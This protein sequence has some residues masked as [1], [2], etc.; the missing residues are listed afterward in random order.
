MWKSVGNA[1]PSDAPPSLEQAKAALVLA[2]FEAATK[3]IESPGESYTSLHG[4]LKTLESNLETEASRSK[5]FPATS[6]GRR[7]ALARWMTD[8]RHPLTAR[9]AVNHIW[10][11][12]FGSAGGGLVP[13]VFDFGRKGTPPTHPELLDWLAVEFMEHGWSMKHLHRLM[14][15]SAAYRMSSSQIENQKSN[16][17]GDSRPER[18]AIFAERGRSICGI[19][20]SASSDWTTRSRHSCNRPG[21][22]GNTRDVEPC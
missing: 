20:K 21:V 14:V 4:A 19:T 1:K 10:S 6:T 3:I 12:H 16:R 15:T 13:T 9:V 2:A 18:L 8:V 22:K 11:R 17:A 7:T 5:P